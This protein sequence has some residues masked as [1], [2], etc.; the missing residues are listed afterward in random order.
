LVNAE[1][2]PASRGGA[3]RASAQGKLWFRSDPAHHTADFAEP[4]GLMRVDYVL[5]SRDLEVHDAAVFW[6]GDDDPL[7]RLTG[8]GF[9]V[10]SSDHRLVW[11]DV[12]HP[13]FP[14]G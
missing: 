6:P 3:D 12:S 2:T 5:P 13:D 9:P 4:A 10:V 1:V 8:P 14:P 11:V 7:V